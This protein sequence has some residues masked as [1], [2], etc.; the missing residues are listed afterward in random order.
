[1]FYLYDVK[2]INA[3]FDE[4]HSEDDLLLDL[5]YPVPEED[6]D[7]D[8]DPVWDEPSEEVPLD[9]FCHQCLADPE[10]AAGLL[11]YP[12][13]PAQ[14]KIWHYLRKDNLPLSYYIL[15]RF[16]RTLPEDAPIPTPVE[17]LAIRIMTCCLNPFRD[18]EE[19]FTLFRS[20]NL[21]YPF[22]SAL[23]AKMSQWHLT[24][25][26]EPYSLRYHVCRI[27]LD[28][29]ETDFLNFHASS[30]R[31]DETE[32]VLCYLL[33]Q[34]V[35]MKRRFFPAK[36]EAPSPYLS[37]P[38]KLKHYLDR[39][40][41]GQEQ[42][43]RIMAS[44]VYGHMVHIQNRDEAF[45]PN[46]VLMIGPSG[47]GKSEILRRIREVTGLPMI[48]TD[49]SSLGMGQ[50]RGR[51]VDDML[52]SL[53][54]N[55]GRDL[56]KAEHGIIFMDEFDKLLTPVYSSDG[57]NKSEEVQMQMLTM[58]EGSVME[59]RR[60][61]QLLTMD[62]SHI[63]F[64]LSGA[65][66]GIRDFIRTDRLKKDRSSGNIGFGGKLRKE[67][68]DAICSDNIN[69]DVLI[70]FGM[71]RELAG[72]IGSIAVLE[73]LQEDDLV[74]ILTESEDS[75]I[76]RY[77]N[78]VHMINGSELSVSQNLIRHIAHEAC[79]DETGARALF[80]KTR[81][82]LRDLLFQLPERKTPARIT[83]DMGDTGDV[84]IKWEE[85]AQ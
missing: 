30:P 46:L 84:L 52:F 68:N 59:I 66:H 22:F 81:H 82:H 1:M 41:I 54:E 49:V 79:N 43:K 71:K 47:S 14:T 38:I 40:I 57:A 51:H 11:P 19:G 64:V 4:D 31:D 26:Q 85:I 55:A 33:G 32:N 44:A 34:I 37:S 83:A 48:F 6:P 78:E 61:R 77:K 25:E 58:L 76:T 10:K 69:H 9:N 23:R 45:P 2:K 12:E 20:D 16:S 63:L 35:E 17:L 72:R 74:R 29:L 28:F 39:F 36:E 24:E 21:Y 62:T 7:A 5:S 56:D 67:M 8:V 60:D 65:F 75:L 80:L 27:I 50:Y 70:D 53:W 3:F 73:K 18:E 42:A 15:V 13:L